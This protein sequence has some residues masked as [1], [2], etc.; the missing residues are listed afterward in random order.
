MD[1][2]WGFNTEDD[3]SIY[4]TDFNKMVDHFFPPFLTTSLDKEAAK[5]LITM[6]NSSHKFVILIYGNELQSDVI[7]CT[8]AYINV[9]GVMD[10]R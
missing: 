10:G 1:L 6:I 3:E 2:C 4:D 7:T 8:V 9:T 5:E